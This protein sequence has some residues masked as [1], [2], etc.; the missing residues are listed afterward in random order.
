MPFAL[1]TFGVVMIVAGASGCHLALGAALGR[2]MVGDSN[3]KGFVYWLAAIGAVGA[4]GYYSPFRG[5]AGAFMALIIISMVLKNGG[6]FQKFSQALASGPASVSGGDAAAN[7][8]PAPP[9]VDIN[10]GGASASPASAP[11]SSSTSWVN[12]AV[13]VA[14]L[15]A[16]A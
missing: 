10:L 14:T 3:S 16:G 1:V 13:Q 9:T 7:A 15:A 8:T 5:F 6:F 2:D 11:S 4:V 12:T